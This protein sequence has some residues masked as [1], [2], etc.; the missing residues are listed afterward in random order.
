MFADVWLVGD[1]VVR[2]PVTSRAEQASFLE[3]VRRAAGESPPELLRE[4]G[5]QHREG[6]GPLRV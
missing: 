5:H 3:Q 2:L 1:D 4:Q 6:A